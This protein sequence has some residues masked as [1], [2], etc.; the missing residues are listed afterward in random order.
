MDKIPACRELIN[1]HFYSFI[2][3]DIFGMLNLHLH[4][5]FIEMPIFK[6]STI[7]EKLVSLPETQ[8]PQKMERTMFEIVTTRM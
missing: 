2:N 8:M 5:L 1:I 4:H 7:N 6:K 3:S